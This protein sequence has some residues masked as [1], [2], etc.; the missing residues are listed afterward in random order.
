[1]FLDGCMI[2][3]W[4]KLSLIDYPPYLTSVIFL[5]GCNFKCG[6][7]HNPDL[8]L[9]PSKLPNIDL[10]TVLDYLKKRKKWI[11]A[12]CITG[13]EPTLHKNLFEI[14]SKIKQLSLKVKL[15]TNGSNPNIVK[16]LL[17]NNLLD[18][19]AMDIK[20]ALNKYDKLAGVKVEKEK[21]KETVALIK[22][23]GI[24]YEFRTTLVP[25]LI[26]KT[27]LLN[28]GKWLKGSKRF[29]IQNFNSSKPLINNK[30]RELAP[31]SPQELIK[32]AEW[33]KPYFK[34]T[35]VRF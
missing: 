19:I 5:G 24:D 22:N 23:S 34:K 25:G 18:Y 7:C 3:G 27:D 14:I 17:E 9:N 31:Y 35:E 26:S 8:V 29:V 1:M 28:I 12:V 11:Q 30:L 20:T 16:E 13:G 33:L 4:Q 32:L 15:D 21:I 2:K 6:F 10:D